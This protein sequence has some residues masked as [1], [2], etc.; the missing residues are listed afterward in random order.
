[1]TLEID[2]CAS[3]MPM[4]E[5]CLDKFAATSDAAIIRGRM[6]FEPIKW[7]TCLSEK[8]ITKAMPD[9]IN[10][11]GVPIKESGAHLLEWC[12]TVMSIACG[13]AI[14][15]IKIIEESHLADVGGGSWSVLMS[16][17]PLH[18]CEGQQAQL[19]TGRTN[20]LNCLACSESYL[21]ELSG[22]SVVDHLCES[23]FGQIVETN[24]THSNLEGV[25]CH[26][27]SCDVSEAW[28][29]GCGNGMSTAVY[30]TGTDKLLVDV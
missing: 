8:M 5:N 6:A 21:K 24:S 11:F 19:V 27:L 25:F 17:I 26:G 9:L 12:K 20:M 1:M 30:G 10:C 15:C 29:D 2:G 16:R 7:L 3:Y 13:L 23:V 22:S 28:V 14:L 18:T 4:G